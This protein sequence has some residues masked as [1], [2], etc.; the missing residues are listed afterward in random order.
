VRLGRDAAELEALGH[1]IA[2]RRVALC[3]NGFLD[4][5][6]ENHA[7]DAIEGPLQHRVSGD[8]GYM[9][10]LVEPGARPPAAI[11]YLASPRIGEG[12]AYY[13]VT[14]RPFE[15]NGEPA[16]LTCIAGPDERLDDRH[17]YEPTA[18]YPDAIL[19]RLDAF[20]RPLLAEGRGEPL[21][22]THTWHG[23]MAYTPNQV[24]QIGPEPRNALL[25]YNLGCNG[26]GF[27]P[28]IYGGHRLARI[29]GGE[30]LAPSL[31]DPR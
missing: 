12:Q 31:F 20:I 25:L 26:V 10:A 17:S 13:Y 7:G 3:T 6:I 16:T 5:V 23:L 4:H 11:S 29:V 2:A 9:A 22:Y 30:R 19:E 15:R 24:R 21:P 1:R 8:V 27:L 18:S 28:S 14:R